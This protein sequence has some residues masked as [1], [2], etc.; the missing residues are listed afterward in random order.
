MKKYFL[1]LSVLV[2]TFL[3]S[4]SWAAGNSLGPASDFKLEGIDK[5]TYALSNYRGKP[6]V[7]F[8]W[9]T[10]CPFCRKAAGELK[11]TYPELQQQ[12]WELFAIDVQESA[13]KAQNFAESHGVA[14][15]VLLD[16]DGRV[17]NAYGV[18]GIPTFVLINSRGQIVFKDNY[19][20]K[21]SYKELIS[22]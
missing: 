7:L 22:N 11:N 18:L 16:K 12:G 5:T 1:G 20:P 21:D 3:G 9:A 4:L 6:V 19:F 17:A 2:L 10:W 14:F 15:K 13:Y 8:F